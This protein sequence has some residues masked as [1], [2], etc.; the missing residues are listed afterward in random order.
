VTIDFEFKVQGLAQLNSELQQLPVRLEKNVLRGMIR[1]AA[2][3]VV[4]EARARAPVLKDEADGREP[5]AL[6]R[7]VRAM[8]T[9]VRGALVKGGVVAGSAK[10]TLKTKADAFYARFIE[11]G[12]AKMAAIP[13]LRPA[14]H[15]KSAA[16]IDAAA[17]YVRERVA[18]GDLKK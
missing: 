10:K 3:P 2:K 4:E 7:S 18:A 13:F 8:S 5:G 9:V 16:A 1:A 17:R 15:G 14:A 11:Y 12:T 6:R